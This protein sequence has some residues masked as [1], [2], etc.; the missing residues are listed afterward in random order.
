MSLGA[1]SYSDAMHEYSS[2]L[3][4]LHRMIRD[5]KGESD[6]AEELRDEMDSPWYGMTTVEL[7]MVRGLSEDLHALVDHQCNNSANKSAILQKIQSLVSRAEWESL[8]DYIRQVSPQLTQYELCYLRGTAW[9]EIGF[10]VVAVEFY[11]KM[12]ASNSFLTVT[13]QS[14]FFSA[15]LESKNYEEAFGFAKTFNDETHPLLWMQFGAELANK[16]FT[17]SSFNGELL[18]KAIQ[19]ELHALQ[20][21]NKDFKKKIPDLRITEEKWDRLK[22][23][24]ELN[25]AILYYLN[26]DFPAASSHVESLLRSDPNHPEALLIK[27]QL[28]SNQTPAQSR[29][30]GQWIGS[31]I[32]PLRLITSNNFDFFPVTAN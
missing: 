20:L 23:E 12:M 6:E 9:L 18:Q 3:V 7:A 29:S 2:K 31:R 14:A 27:T 25:L 21:A 30:I 11:R 32:V 24:L 1:K 19:V 13:E 16:I 10:P 15:L 4:N 8:L 17:E 28:L 26:L 22:N 5:G